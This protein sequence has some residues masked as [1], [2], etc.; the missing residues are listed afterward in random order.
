MS[1]AII[2]RKVDKVV[3][4]NIDGYPINDSNYL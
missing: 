2:G 3:L 1:N 4:Y